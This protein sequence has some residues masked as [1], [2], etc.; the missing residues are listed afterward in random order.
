MFE[1]IPTILTPAELLD[2][3]LGRASK[4][5]KVDKVA[6]YRARKTTIARAESAQQAVVD[7]L[8]GY[9]RKFPS[10]DKVNTYERELIDVVVGVDALRKALARVEG[11]AAVVEAL[12]GEARTQMKRA[13]SAGDA[14]AAH[15]RLAGRLASVV[16]QLEKPLAFLAHARAVFREIPE[17][18]PGDATIVIAGYPNVGKSSLL[19]RLSHARPEIA[20]YAFTTK[21]ANVGHFSWPEGPAHRS[22]RYQLV[23]TPG[24]L[25]QPPAKRNQIER[26]AA[27]ALSYL[28]DVIVFML[29][30]SE[31]CGYPLVAQERLLASVRSEFPQVPLVL[32]ENKADLLRGEG[33]GLAVSCTTGA[34][35]AELKRAIVEAVPADKYAQAFPDEGLPT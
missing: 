16:N 14:A 33:R 18:T 34:G 29:D 11:A 8:Q 19:A 25:D 9:V 22:R 30:P 3:A 32:V 31:A 20:P 10:L 6:L 13:G 27:L 35:L 4:I 26:Q 21:R 17:V 2:K 5:E 24:L 1:Q 15:R 28:S 12:G 23:D 7:T